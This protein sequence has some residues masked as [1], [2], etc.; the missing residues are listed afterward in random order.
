MLGEFLIVI[1]N[2]ASKYFKFPETSVKKIYYFFFTISIKKKLKRCNIS[3]RK[4]K[5]VQKY[6]SDCSGKTYN[7]KIGLDPGLRL[8]YMLV[9]EMVSQLNLKTLHITECLDFIYG[10]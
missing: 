8:K 1:Q 2:G 5:K 6:E 10:F 9:F 3:K 4:K 7:N